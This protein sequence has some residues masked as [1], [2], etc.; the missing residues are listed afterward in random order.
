MNQEEYEMTRIL[1]FDLILKPKG[2]ELIDQRILRVPI[3]DDHA[4][5][6]DSALQEA[7][8]QTGRRLGIYRWE[9]VREAVAKV[10]RV[11]PDL[12]CID[13]GGIFPSLTGNPRDPISGIFGLSILR[14][15][16]PSGKFFVVSRFCPPEIVGVLRK[17]GAIGIYDLEDALR[18]PDVFAW[19]FAGALEG[20]EVLSPKARM[21]DDLWRGDMQRPEITPGTGPIVLQRPGE[22]ITG[23]DADDLIRGLLNFK[24][25]EVQRIL[26][27]S[28]VAW[29]RYQGFHS[30]SRTFHI[31]TTAVTPGSVNVALATGHLPAVFPVAENDKELL[32][33]LADNCTVQEAA[34]HLGFSKSTVEKN[35]S[36]MRSD[37]RMTH[38]AERNPQLLAQILLGLTPPE[39]TIL[40]TDQILLEPAEEPQ[41][42]GQQIDEQGSLELVPEHKPEHKKEAVASAL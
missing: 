9:D 34:D 16:Y 19:G 22:E 10:Q 2:N 42:D 21:A 39:I 26:S 40:K 8:N 11:A 38:V 27:K 33:L 23:P 30:T 37:H 5:R 18:R 41:D 20:Q 12:L 28:T 35:V 31:V 14:S 29:A 3:V 24:G 15:V 13:L 7:S 17:L 4:G 36:R 6:F 32:Q 1:G 25:A